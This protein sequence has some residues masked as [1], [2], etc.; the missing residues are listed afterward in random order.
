MLLSLWFQKGP[1][2]LSFLKVTL[3]IIMSLFNKVVDLQRVTSLKQR[4]Q[5]RC[6]PVSFN[7]YLRILFLQN[8][9]F[10]QFHFLFILTS[11]A[12][13]RRCSSKFHNICRRTPVAY[14]P[15]NLLKTLVNIAKCL[16]R[17]FLKNTSESANHIGSCFCN[18]N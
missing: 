13:V 7:K 14:K 9:C 2:R 5:C 17:A 10:L 12:G 4:P 8:T 6:F 16:R 18:F 1:Y 3:I 11:E 15:E